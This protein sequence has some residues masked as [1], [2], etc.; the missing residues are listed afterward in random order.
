MEQVEVAVIGAG[1][2][3]LAIA[4]SLALAGREVVLLEAEQKP[5]MHT[6]SRNSEVV[7]AGFYYTPGSLKAR[8]CQE[9]RHKL[10]AYAERHGVGLR[11]PGKLVVAADQSEL[12]ILEGYV[13]RGRHNGTTELRLLTAE[14]ARALEPEVRCAGAVFSP[15]TGIVDSHGL[16]AALRREATEAGAAVALNARVESGST[17]REGAVL[18]VSG[19]ADFELRC[20]V[21][22][23]SAGLWAPAVAASI[24]GAPQPP[25]AMFARGQYFLLAGRS[26]FT[27]L[28]YP[29]AI[30]GG[31]GVHVTLDLAGQTRF[32]P[33]VE[34]IDGVDYSFDESRQGAFEDVIRRYWP[35]LPE[36]ALRPGYT[37]IRPKLSK[38][39]HDF[40]I[41]RS[42]PSLV[43]LFG[44]DSPGL[45]SA[46]AI[47]DYVESL[48][49]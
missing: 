2:V 25:A 10:F 49:R 1:V 18:R 27:H 38:A 37:G 14:E 17:S 7:H 46:L 15:K 4:R 13:E 3:G 28:V 6:S 45:T 8:L 23:N 44:I 34:W 39:A 31:L 5:G 35:G 19:E 21:A 30:V 36:G 12:P 26:P 22:V 33:D 42:T 43:N 29:I 47:G 24:E 41:E 48:L 32:G 40:V 20:E 16:M 11:V 9:G